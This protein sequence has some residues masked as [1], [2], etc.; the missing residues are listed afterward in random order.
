[1][2]YQYTKYKKESQDVFAHFV[3]F[4]FMY[5][6]VDYFWPMRINISNK[7]RHVNTF[8]NIFYFFNKPEMFQLTF[9]NVSKIHN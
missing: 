7:I 4:Y 1:M 6:C 3:L 2:R 9:T 8:F 5:I